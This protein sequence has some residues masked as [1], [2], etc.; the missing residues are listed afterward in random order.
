MVAE[1][2]RALARP[3]R[4][5]RIAIIVAASVMVYAGSLLGYHWLAGTSRPL[6]E[7]DLGTSAETVVLVEVVAMH[8]VE[9]RLDV[10]V[11]VEPEDSL[12]DKR[13]GV[14]N[15]DIGVRLHPSINFEDLQYL[16]GRAPAAV[17]TT[18][19]AGG[20][21]GNWPFDS[22]KADKISADLLVGSGS[23]RR[24]LPARVEVEHFL[25]AWEV[26]A[27]RSGPSTQASVESR[28]RGDDVTITL[29]RSKGPL[30]F[31]LGICLILVSLPA[32]ALFVSI[33][34]LRRRKKF[35]PGYATWY[36][37]MLFA[38]LP[39]RNYLPGSPP[40]GAWID[41]AIVLWVLIALVAAMIMFIF[42]WYRQKD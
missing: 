18:I 14:L 4:R 20:D 38:V 37:A 1:S 11:L 8:P 26:Q 41:K 17:T 22:Y 25:N 5:L 33:A 2:P 32:M 36:T 21:V 9:Q 10:K 39:L 30:V 24:F 28:G 16:Q 3:T 23:A 15:T 35:Q 13:L 42:A 29:K 12:M 34:T 27:A 40:P 31:A 7:P 19:A 6:P